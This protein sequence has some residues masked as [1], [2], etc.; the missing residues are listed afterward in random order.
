MIN[1]IK[2]TITHEEIDLFSDWL[3]TYPKLTKGPLTVKFEQEFANWVGT[4]YSVMVNSGSSANLV[5]MATVKKHFNWNDGDE[6][7]TS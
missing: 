2:D 3:K 6:I 5:M 1:L 4:K 7:I